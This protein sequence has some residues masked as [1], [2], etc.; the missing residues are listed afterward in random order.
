MLASGGKGGYSYL[1]V[2]GPVVNGKIEIYTLKAVPSMPCSTGVEY[3][4]LDPASQ[5]RVVSQSFHSVVHN[6]FI[7]Q[8]LVGSMGHG[9]TPCGQ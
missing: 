7:A 2:P 5:S 4:S 6:D 9:Q 1:Y 3:Y 8:V